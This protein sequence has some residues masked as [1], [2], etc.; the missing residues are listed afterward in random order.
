[1]AFF[2]KLDKPLGVYNIRWD[3]G[4]PAKELFTVVPEI[5]KLIVTQHP[6]SETAD[7]AVK[8]LNEALEKFKIVE[9]VPV[10]K[11]REGQGFNYFAIRRILDH[12]CLGLLDQFYRDDWL[13]ENT[14][15]FVKETDA[16][17]KAQALGYVVVEENKCT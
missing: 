11:G 15:L 17:T 10:R 2:S 3:E 12:A 13:H 6:D 8:T 7:S 9:I 1:M 4:T 14:Q 16:I 5:R